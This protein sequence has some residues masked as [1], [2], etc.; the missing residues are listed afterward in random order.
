MISIPV[1]PSG[2][3]TAKALMTRS[4]RRESLI[5]PM[6][7]GFDMKW[8]LANFAPQETAALVKKF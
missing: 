7:R 4:S 5:I 6:K 2:D 8:V 3:L 1:V